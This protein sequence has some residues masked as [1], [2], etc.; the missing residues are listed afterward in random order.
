[1]HSI[2]L[3]EEFP[4]IYVRSYSYYNKSCV[5]VCVGGLR[6]HKGTEEY[7]APE[8]FR[9]HDSGSYDEKVTNYFNLPI[10]DLCCSPLSC[11]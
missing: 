4:T 7:M 8:L 3:E 5:F 1:M 9:S 10:D 6:R 2:A 11:A